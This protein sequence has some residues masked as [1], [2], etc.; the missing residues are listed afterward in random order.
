MTCY[1]LTEFMF[2]NA[3]EI[4]TGTSVL[5]LEDVGCHIVKNRYA[6]SYV[7]DCGARG[8]VPDTATL[9]A[10]RVVAGLKE[11]TSLNDVVTNKTVVNRDLGF[12]VDVHCSA[13]PEAFRGVTVQ[14]YGVDRRLR[15][16]IESDASTRPRSAVRSYLG[17]GNIDLC[18]ALCVDRTAGTSGHVLCKR[19]ATDVQRA[20]V[21]IQ[22]ATY[23]LILSVV[24]ALNN[25]AA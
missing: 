8:T 12:G 18:I 2:D 21:L 10:H 3:G 19:C 22:A 17:A 7:H 4:I 5:P 1:R 14:N 6:T 13:T 16:S 24:V 9:S 11:K 25:N 15:S 23:T 20:S